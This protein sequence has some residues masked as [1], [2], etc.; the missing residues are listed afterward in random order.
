MGN[1]P[2]EDER[3]VELV[4]VQGEME[5]DILAGILESEGIRVL[6]KSNMAHGALPFTV[7]GMGEVKLFV[8][9]EDLTLSRIII[10]EHIAN[11]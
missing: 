10:R 8:M 2:H 4:S 9:E 3:L 11:R 5:A 7:D 1:L 6:K